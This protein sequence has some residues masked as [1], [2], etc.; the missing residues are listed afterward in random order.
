ML[1]LVDG[2]ALLYR[3]FFALPDFS[4]RD[5]PTNAVYGLGSMLHKALTD[6]RPS[7]I[8]VC[9]DAKGP[10]FRNGLLETY[11]QHRP[12]PDAKL[13][14]QFDI[15]R[16]FLDSAGI[17]RLEQSGYEA[18]DLI[19]TLAK[20]YE[21][22][23]SVHILTGDKDMLQLVTDSIH[24]IM[25]KT[26]MSKVID[27][28][29]ATVKE[30]FGLRP[31]QIVDLKSLMGDPSDGYKG[32]PGIGP[33]TAIELLRE[34]D[35]LEGIYEH[36]TAIKKESLKTALE[37][38]KESAELCKV[39]AFLKTDLELDVDLEDMTLKPF[40]STLR[41]FFIKYQLRTLAQRY[42]GLDISAEVSQQ[43]EL[44]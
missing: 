38:G 11:Q 33:K 44:F 17:L 16:E 5:V 23:L 42:L 20:R 3:A 2:N 27:Y 31:E 19:G 15:A 21:E 28:D 30:L 24:V 25:L 32:I 41:D 35:T 37:N 39:L 34:Y 14:P 22:K 12:A 40:P 36:L 10:N 8:A 7:H 4:N 29:P 43:P 1:L 13:V 6:Y 9:F 26:G 18:D